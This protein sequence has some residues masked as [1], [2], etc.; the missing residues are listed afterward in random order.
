ME[1]VCSLQNRI[2][3]DDEE[4]YEC[5]FKEYWKNVK[6][7]EGLTGDDFSAA[8]PNYR[9]SKRF[10][11]HTSCIEG[12]EEKQND[13]N[14]NENYT[15]KH[16]EKQN[17]SNGDEDYT[18]KHKWTKRKRYNSNEFVGWGSKPL[19]SF[20]TYIGRYE[21][22]P[23]TQSE[24]KS[25]IYAYIKEKNLHHPTDKRKFLPDDK[26]FPI[27]RKKVMS[28]YQIFRLLE[29]HLAKELDDSAAEKNHDQNK[30]ISTDKHINNQATCIES[31]LSGLVGK[32]LLKKGDVLIKPSCFASINAKNINLI[33]L[34]RSLVLEL[35]KQHESFVSKV[36]GAFVRAKVD[37]D[38][39]KQRKSY[40]LLRV[41]GNKLHAY[42]ILC[43]PRTLFFF[44]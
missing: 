4:T 14:G 33:Y 44:R 29:F 41:I 39:H 21:I 18:G 42:L 25:L 8:Q 3:L 2:S 31:R 34:K 37:L 24:V 13:S 38:D 11:H 28:K 20:L 19:F 40:H 5:L 1:L 10:V 15:G 27:F 12:E 17:D 23:L 7:K 26:L 9:K 30:S 6:V 16:K 36:V 22:E 32:P 35:S 43:L